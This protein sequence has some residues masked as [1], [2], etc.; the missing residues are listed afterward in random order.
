[1]AVMFFFQS[2]GFDRLSYGFVISL[3]ILKRNICDFHS[4]EQDPLQFPGDLQHPSD[5]MFPGSIEPVEIDPLSLDHGPADHGSRRGIDQG[6]GEV[7][8][9]HRDRPSSL[10]YIF[11]SSW[12]P[13]VVIRYF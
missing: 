1:M 5:E 2:R 6:G 12:R 8:P 3:T 9:P 4:I 13:F 11:F 10:N 7:V